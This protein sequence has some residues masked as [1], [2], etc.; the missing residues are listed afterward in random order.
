MIFENMDC[1]VF[2]GD[3]VI[4]MGSLQSVGNRIL[5]NLGKS[6]VR[7]IGNMFMI[8]YFEFKIRIDNTSCNLL[9]WFD[10]D[11]VL[12]KMYIRLYEIKWYMASAWF[13]N[14]AWH[15]SF[16]YFTH[17]SIL[18]MIFW[19]YFSSIKNCNKAEQ[20]KIEDAEGRL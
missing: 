3:S 4:D 11:V 8:W 16:S 20:R 13:S 14:N 19:N 9:M 12:L 5:D 18:E 7:I 6:Y 17:M 1:I 10:R 2:A 15:G